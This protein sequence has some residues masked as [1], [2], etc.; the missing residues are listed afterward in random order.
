MRWK[1]ESSSCPGAGRGAATGR[2][3]ATVQ[4]G[5]VGLLVTWGKFVIG[6]GSY[7]D[8]VWSVETSLTVAGASVLLGPGPA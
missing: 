5:V 4:V 6:H 1:E 2:P 7:F 8:R 3:A